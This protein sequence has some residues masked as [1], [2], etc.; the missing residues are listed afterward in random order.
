MS[1]Y[2]GAPL[3]L[4]LALV[5]VPAA[6]AGNTTTFT[7]PVGDV[8]TVPDIVSV[9]ATSKDPSTVTVRVDFAG[10][11]RFGAG[12]GFSLLLDADDSRATGHGGDGVD[13]WFVLS[14][15]DGSFR[16]ERWDGSFFSPY[17]STATGV[18]SGN[19]VTTRFDVKELPLAGPVFRLNASTYDDTNQDEAP[20]RPEYFRFE[21]RLRPVAP[22][23][24]FSPAHPVAGKR[25]SVL[26]PGSA[27]CR[28]TIRGRALRPIRRCSWR[29]PKSAAGKRLT[30]VVSA[31]R[32][33]FVI[34]RA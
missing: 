13:Y 17:G 22:R 3:L 11:A 15:A 25:F 31:R 7:D 16:S 5:M 28:A 32:Y 23:A 10:P 2:Q 33:A 29:I 4:L 19:T 9:T 12:V 27:T 20:G 34:R 8:A 24:R 26:R 6:A 21:T 18:A 1:Q 30:V 14:R